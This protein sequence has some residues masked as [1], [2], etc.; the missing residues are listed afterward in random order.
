M[1]TVASHGT[2]RSAPDASVGTL[3]GSVGNIGIATQHGIHGRLTPSDA[4]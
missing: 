2:G 1:T 3:D 4:V